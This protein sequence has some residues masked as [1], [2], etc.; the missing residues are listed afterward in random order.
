MSSD[1]SHFFVEN[2]THQF[3]LEVQKQLAKD[4]LTA[5]KV[6]PE[7]FTLISYSIDSIISLTSIFISELVETSERAVLQLLYIIDIPEKEFKSLLLQKDFIHSLTIATIEREAKKVY[8]KEKYS[9]KK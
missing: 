1:L 8:F 5:T 4:F 2:D 9:S 3:R 6:Y 7:D